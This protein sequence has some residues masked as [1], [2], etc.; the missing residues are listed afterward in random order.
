MHKYVTIGGIEEAQSLAYKMLSIT[1]YQRKPASDF[2]LAQAMEA[3]N[4]PCSSCLHRSTCKLE[5]NRFREYLSS[6]ATNLKKL[7]KQGKISA[8]TRSSYIRKEQRLRS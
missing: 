8:L 7:R 6:P 2:E 4:C 3:K 5:C 1:V